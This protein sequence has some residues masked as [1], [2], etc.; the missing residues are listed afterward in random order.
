MIMGAP[1]SAKAVRNTSAP[2]KMEGRVTGTSPSK[3]RQGWI[4][5]RRLLMIDP[6]RRAPVTIKRTNGYRLSV[7]ARTIPCIP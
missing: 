2:Q 4:C 6:A 5:L 3:T 7:N 1:N